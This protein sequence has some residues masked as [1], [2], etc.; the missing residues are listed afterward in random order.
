M[1]FRNAYMNDRPSDPSKRTPTK[2]KANIVPNVNG[3]FSIHLSDSSN[4]ALVGAE[5]TFDAIVSVALSAIRMLT[6]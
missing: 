6:G 3:I 5:K 1:R 4:G 2:Q